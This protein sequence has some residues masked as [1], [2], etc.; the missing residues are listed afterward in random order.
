MLEAHQLNFGQIFF[1]NVKQ[2]NVLDNANNIY[3]IV[4]DK[5]QWAAT[6][7]LETDFKHR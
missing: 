1:T 3:R 2:L 7:L 5:R 4:P 6:F